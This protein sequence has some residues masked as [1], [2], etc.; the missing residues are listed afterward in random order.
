M[1]GSSMSRVLVISVSILNIAIAH[2]ALAQSNS[3][4]APDPFGPDKPG[5][6]HAEKDLRVFG[7]NPNGWL[8]PI[9]TLNESLPSWIQFGAQFRDRAESQGG[10]GYR[11]ITDV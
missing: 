7:P 2:H 5:G 9:T 10:L 6:S 1:H 4:S 11:N 3:S 8:F